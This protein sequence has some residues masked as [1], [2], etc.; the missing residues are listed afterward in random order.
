[1]ALRAK[2]APGSEAAPTWLSMP[3]GPLDVDDERLEQQLKSLANL[4]D[5]AA[6][7]TARSMQALSHPHA[8]PA[9]PFQALQCAV[10]G[11]I[12]ATA[13]RSLW[14]ACPTFNGPAMREELKKIPQDN[15]EPVGIQA[16]SP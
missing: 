6:A 11:A 14:A 1:M 9:R 13:A 8:V 5:I 2:E 7:H 16:E 15:S 4:T 12:L 10:S 3:D